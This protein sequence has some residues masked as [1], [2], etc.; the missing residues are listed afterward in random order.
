M[1]LPVL[2]ERRA[3]LMYQA[4][5]HEGRWHIQGPDG[6]ISPSGYSSRRQAERIARDID[7]ARAL[8][9]TVMDGEVK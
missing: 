9:F 1:Y 5:M 6:S 4:I 3:F 7:N 8:Y 2:H